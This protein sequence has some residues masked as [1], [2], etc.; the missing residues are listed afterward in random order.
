MTFNRTQIA[1]GALVALLAF[2]ALGIFA[3][4]PW[5]NAAAQEQLATPVTTLPRTITVLGEGTVA[6][7]PDVA[8]IQVG[9][10][11]KG[12][13]AQEASAEAA[14]T[15]DAI[16]TALTKAGV[17]TK[18]IQTTGYNIYVEQRV[19][20]D[21]VATDEVIYHVGNSVSVTV[22][23]L[24]TVGDVLDASIAAGANSIYG[25]NFSVDDPDEVMAEARSLAAA[26]ALARAEEL[27]G[28][29]GVALGEVVSISE[30]INGMAVP[31]FDSVN[32]SMGLGSAAGPISPGELEMTAR[33]QV[34]YAIAGPA[35]D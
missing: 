6:T 23:D 31:M 21:G 10:E 28:L 5:N 17:A 34:V 16:L 1:A 26:D 35:A 9:V 30:V 11:V 18:D 15:M 8:Q 19:G 24:D 3:L 33:L 14:E 12:D 7:Q 2:A 4:G 25:V 32:A 20:P 13:N 22:R 29:H 27:A